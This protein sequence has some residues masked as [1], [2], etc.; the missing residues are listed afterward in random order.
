MT[1]TERSIGDAEREHWADL[2]TMTADQFEAALKDVQWRLSNLY[3][4]MDKEGRTVRFRPNEA[5]QRFMDALWYRNLV[6]KARQRGFSTLIQILMLDAALFEHQLRAAVIA[7]DM[8][9]ARKIFRDKIKFAYNR[10]PPTLREMRP[11]T[12]NSTEELMLGGNGSSLYVATTSRGGTLQWLHVSEFGAICAN[13]P[14][15]AEEIETGALPSVSPSGITCIESTIKGISGKFSDMCRRALARA[16]I[17]VALSNLEYRVHF[18]GWHDAREYETDPTNVRINAED[19]AM[20]NRMEAA[21]GQPISDRKR[22]WYVITRDET[23]SGDQAKMWS[24]YPTT[25]EEAFTVST[26]G[27]WLADVLSAARVQRRI[28]KGLPY[29]PELPVNFFWDLGVSDDIAIWCHQFDGIWDN[30]VDYVEISEVPYSVPVQMLQDRNFRVWGQTFLPHDGNQ[31]RP[32]ATS[33]KTP[34]DMLEDLHVP[35]IVIVPQTPEL[36]IGNNLM[37]KAFSRYRF[38]EEKCADGITHLS[39]YM[40]PWIKRYSVWGPGYV[41]NGHQHAADALRQ[42][43]QADEAKLI[44]AITGRGAT[45][46]TKINRRGSSRTT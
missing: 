31:R 22:A 33:L 27:H 36:T 28:V 39:G 1:E 5:Q 24:E 4:I 2:A 46:S 40:K 42:H 19:A 13:N 43:A 44:R 21:I 11:L 45:S 10:L 15:H 3:W 14:E 7:Q 9:I 29:N 17:G 18:A 35:N 23:F 20:F 37:R 32:G 6:P 12:T 8:N 34:K 16:Q 41:K 38:D 25:I 30:F 26:E